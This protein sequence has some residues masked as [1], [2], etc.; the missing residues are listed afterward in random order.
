MKRMVPEVD[1]GPGRYSDGN[2]AE[3]RLW[4]C[5]LEE[6]ELLTSA[7]R[8]GAQAQTPP[9]NVQLRKTGDAP[10]RIRIYPLPFNY[11]PSWYKLHPDLGESSIDILG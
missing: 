4:S 11:Q 2:S 10:P 1:R 7:K 9:I 8:P 5:G 6:V 3:V